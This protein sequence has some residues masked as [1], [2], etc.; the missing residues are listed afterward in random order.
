[1]LTSAVLQCSRINP[2]KPHERSLVQYF[3]GPL[4]GSAW[5]MQN[6]TAE[7]KSSRQAHAEGGSSP[8]AWKTLCPLSR[9]DCVTHR[10]DIQVAEWMSENSEPLETQISAQ[11]QCEA[12]KWTRNK[13]TQTRGWNPVSKSLNKH[14]KWIG[15]K[16]RPR[17]RERRKTSGPDYTTRW[18][19]DVSSPLFVSTSSALLYQ[20]VQ[21]AL[22]FS[23]HRF[24]S[25]FSLSFSVLVFSGCCLQR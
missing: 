22:R 25:V 6:V 9:R 8:S 21:H 11:T 4:K 18:Q 14:W 17:S 19:Q 13:T 10:S 5:I 1:M 24:V 20:P 7:F 2:V 16:I 3:K 15:V 12:S 23:Q